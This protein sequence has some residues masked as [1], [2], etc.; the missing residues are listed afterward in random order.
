MKVTKVGIIMYKL[1]IYHM[2]NN[3]LLNDHMWND[4]YSYRAINKGYL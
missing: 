3:M 1:K 2:W 4:N